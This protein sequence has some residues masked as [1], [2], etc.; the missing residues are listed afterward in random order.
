LNLPVCRT[1]GRAAAGEILGSVAVYICLCHGYTDHQI[2]RMIDGDR[3]SLAQIYRALGAPPK[4]GKCVP[5]VR[6]LCRGGLSADD[7]ET[8]E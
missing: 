7:G 1:E 3:R 8:S 6:D 4:C 5:V 2:R